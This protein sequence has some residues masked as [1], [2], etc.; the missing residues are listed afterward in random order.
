MFLHAL[1]AK[2][3]FEVKSQH[4][5]FDWAFVHASWTLTRFSARAGT[6]SYEVVADHAYN[7]SCAHMLVR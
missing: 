1:R 7:P 5:L 4:P 3:G 6:T 2:I